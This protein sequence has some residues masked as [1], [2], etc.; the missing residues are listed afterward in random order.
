M[1]RFHPPFDGKRI[2]GDYQKMIFHDTFLESCAAEPNGCQVDDI[3]PED[4]M[5]FE[6]DSIIEAIEKGFARCPKCLLIEQELHE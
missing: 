5:T 2:I 4:V 3:P 1:K 6:S